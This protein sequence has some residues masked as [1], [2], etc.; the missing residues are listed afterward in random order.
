MTTTATSEKTYVEDVFSTYTYTGNGGTQ[1]INN[2]IDLAGKGG[3]V[4]AKARNTAGTSH[5]LASTEA[6]VN[7]SNFYNLLTTNGTNEYLSYASGL[8]TFNNNGFTVESSNLNDV[9]YD[10]SSWTFREAPKFFD[11]VSYTGNGVAGRQIAHSLGI[12]PGMVIV[13][14][15]SQS[16]NWVVW[17]RN[18]TPAYITYLNTTNG[19]I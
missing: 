17:H 14:A 3:L 1:T 7:G 18:Q 10:F 12:A 5:W 8:K 13:K 11:V 9:G 16:D 2:G 6:P 19:Q 4:W 15:T